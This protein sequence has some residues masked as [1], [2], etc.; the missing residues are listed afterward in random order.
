MKIFAK[1]NRTIISVPFRDRKTIQTTVSALQ[2]QPCNQQAFFNHLRARNHWNKRQHE[3]T[4]LLKPFFQSPEHRCFVT[5]RHK[6]NLNTRN[7]LIRSQ[8]TEIPNSVIQFHH[9]ILIQTQFEIAGWNQ[10]PPRFFSSIHHADAI[11]FMFHVLSSFYERHE[12]INFQLFSAPLPHPMFLENQYCYVPL[13]MLQRIY[14]IQYKKVTHLIDD[15]NIPECDL[16]KA[17]SINR[18]PNNI[19][20]I[21]FS[22]ENLKPI[23]PLNAKN[24]RIYYQRYSSN[25]PY[26]QS[27]PWFILK[28]QLGLK[29]RAEPNDVFILPWKNSHILDHKNLF[30]PTALRPQYTQLTFY[31][32]GGIQFQSN[33]TWSP[34]TV[35]FP[36]ATQQKRPDNIYWPH[37]LRNH[38]DPDSLNNI[39]FPYGFLEITLLRTLPP[40]DPREICL[41][42]PDDANPQKSYTALQSKVNRLARKT[43]PKFLTWSDPTTQIADSFSRDHLNTK[44]LNHLFVIYDNFS[45]ATHTYLQKLQRF[46]MAIYHDQFRLNLIQHNLH[47]TEN[48]TMKQKMQESR[49]T[50]LN[51]RFSHLQLTKKYAQ[52]LWQIHL[53]RQGIL[54]KAYTMLHLQKFLT[55]LKSNPQFATDEIYEHHLIG[56]KVFSRN[57]FKVLDTTDLEHQKTLPVLPSLTFS[58]ALLTQIF[59]LFD[60]TLR[61]SIRFFTELRNLFTTPQY[62]R[63]KPFLA[64]ISLKELNEDATL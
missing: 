45:V 46:H 60:Y 18:R 53:T 54:H 39:I 33:H 49:V 6:I 2:A 51:T 58:D 64:Q 43:N 9:S 12:R 35:A 36:M 40:P 38:C 47:N 16:D 14:Q 41:T 4:F 34:H 42:L 50:T 21:G 20:L 31:Y 56:N 32:P 52:K 55:N 27:S 7:S 63:I 1:I 13:N 3:P 11:T 57:R 17:V 26:N 28:I 62:S 10:Q 23:V 48:D 8:K 29:L 15:F 61:N 37:Y 22:G 5:T 24:D 30:T 19:Y 44:I 25:I 59:R